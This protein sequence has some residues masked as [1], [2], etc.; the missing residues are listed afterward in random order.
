MGMNDKGQRRTRTR[1]SAHAARSPLGHPR[2]EARRE[3]APVTVQRRRR[4]LE[5]Q[6][7]FYEDASEYVSRSSGEY[8][9]RKNKGG[10]G[11]YSRTRLP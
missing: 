7:E 11:V 10:F 8:Q 1:S 3:S 6:F 2:R 4:T 9:I 5:K